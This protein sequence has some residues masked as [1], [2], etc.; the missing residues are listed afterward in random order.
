MMTT[1]FFSLLFYMAEIPSICKLRLR[2]NIQDLILNELETQQ[3]SVQQP[4]SNFDQATVI[5]AFRSNNPLPPPQYQP[6]QNISNQ[7]RTPHT[8]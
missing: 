8:D 4:C 3:N 1:T 5:E 7:F 6:M 2:N